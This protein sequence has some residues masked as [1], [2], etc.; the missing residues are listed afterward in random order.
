MS[1]LFD[2]LHSF[3]QERKGLIPQHEL[4]LLTPDTKFEIFDFLRVFNSFVQ[5]AYARFLQKSN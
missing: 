1:G 3:H 4:Y 5:Y 2:M